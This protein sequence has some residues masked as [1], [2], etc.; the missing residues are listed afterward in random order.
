MTTNQVLFD[1]TGS[2]RDDFEFTGLSIYAPF[3]EYASEYNHIFN[4]QASSYI[5]IR[6]VYINGGGGDGVYLAG[7][8]GSTYADHVLIDH[9]WVDHVTRNGISVISAND[10]NVTNSR[11]TNDG[12]DPS[13]PA[14]L[15]PGI[16]IEPNVG[17]DRLTNLNFS[18]IYTSGNLGPGF[19]LAIGNETNASQPVTITVNNLYSN[20]DGMGSIGTGCEPASAFPG[21]I[22]I[23]NP[24]SINSASYGM[25]LLNYAV[26]CPVLTIKNPYILN[27]NGST[28]A[29]ES[30]ASW[31]GGGNTFKYGNI[32]IQDAKIIDN[33]G[34]SKITWYYTLTDYSSIGVGNFHFSAKQLSGATHGTATEGPGFSIEE[35]ASIA[36]ATPVF[37]ASLGTPN[38][39]FHKTLTG[40][41]TSSTIVNTIPG[42][43]VRFQWCQ[44]GSNT[45]TFAYPSGTKGGT[46]SALAGTKCRTQQFIVDVDGATLYSMGAGIDN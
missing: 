32:D 6:G 35:P 9:I 27:P 28:S 31:A 33:R 2:S 4:L 8:G 12:P 46:T 40:N 25:Y 7:N 42:Q 16:D 3:A 38:P 22:T 18:N 24:T 44:T 13:A 39:V 26:A 45:Y 43:I 19:Q 23:T 17:T 20:A 34:T 10:L 14:Y 29:Q 21:N 41:V 30:F 15:N 37:D 5:T 11:F 1:L 36:G